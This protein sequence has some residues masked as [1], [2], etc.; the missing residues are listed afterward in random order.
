MNVDLD[1]YDDPPSD[2]ATQ[3][4]RRE[5]LLDQLGWLADEAAALRP[6]LATLPTWAVEEAPLQGQLTAKE[7]LAALARRDRE[8]YPRRIA[9]LVAEDVPALD[10]A[11]DVADASA[12]DRSLDDLLAEVGEARAAFIEAVGSVPADDW[13]RTATLDA[14][15][16]AETITLYELVLRIV[17]HDADRLRDLAYRLHEADLSERPPSSAH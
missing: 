3:A 2:P 7:T 14:G 10:P 11:E 13:A 16:G 8:V 9:R 5:A 1:R 6:A 15:E 17:R 4:A 12:N